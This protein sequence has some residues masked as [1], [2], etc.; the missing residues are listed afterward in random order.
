VLTEEGEYAYPWLGLQGTD[1]SLALI[2]AIDLPA[3]TRGALV[4]QVSVGRPRRKAG[5][6]GSDE[7]VDVGGLELKARGDVIIAIDDQAMGGMDDLI[8]YLVKETRP[9]D[10]VT[11]TILRD[12]KEQALSVELG[13]RPRPTKREKRES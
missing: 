5:L 8:T 3:G 13:E 9:G 7:T 11:L 6:R 4:K 12:G 2:E 10:E 1:L